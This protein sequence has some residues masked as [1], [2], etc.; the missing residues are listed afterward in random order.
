MHYADQIH[1]WCSLEYTEYGVAYF[2]LYSDEAD[3]IVL[4]VHRILLLIAAPEWS[5]I[6]ITCATLPA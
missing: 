3:I 5:F 1:F 2:K 6:W 4:V